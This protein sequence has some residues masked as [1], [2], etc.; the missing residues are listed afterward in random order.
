MAHLDGNPGYL[1]CDALVLLRHTP[2]LLRL[3]PFCAGAWI[4][5]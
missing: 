3:F 5:G 4:W 2:S 1:D